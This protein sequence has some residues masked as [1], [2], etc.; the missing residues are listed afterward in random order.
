MKNIFKNLVV[1]FVALLVFVPVFAFAHQ[2]RITEQK[3]TTVIDPEISKAYYGK[4]EGEPQMY[5]IDA[6]EPFDLYVNVL[7][8]DIKEQKKDVYALIIKDYK[9]NEPFAFLD[10]VNFE[11]TKFF[12][13]F[14]FDSYLKGPEYRAHVEAGRYD[15]Y[16]WSVNND[17]KYSLA[18][19]EKESF[20]IG[21]TINAINLIPK[22]KKDF[23]GESPISFILSI[24]GIGY[25]L[26]M[27]V[28]AFIFGFIYRLILKF[29]LKKST[30]KSGKNLNKRD[31]VVRAILGAILLILAITTAWSPILLFFAGFCFFEA[32]FSWCAIYS[33]IGKNTC[34]I[35]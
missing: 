11:W 9:M 35:Q 16:V 23:F 26:V 5:T 32:I 15:I 20:G 6:K 2:P 33:A 21:E 30:Q 8:P 18:I 13:P 22:I 28:F 3:E 19:G 34:P 17:S 29:W 14:G 1:F 12:E 24:F 31:R 25:I 7:I 10:G 27:F 4:L